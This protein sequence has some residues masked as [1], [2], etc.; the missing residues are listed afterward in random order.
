MLTFTD[1]LDQLEARLPAVPARLVHL[2]RTLAGATY[3][4]VTS[5]VATVAAAT[6]AFL[7]TTKT[8]GKTV[9][10][11]ATAQGR[12][13]ARSAEREATRTLDAAI[14]AVDDRP[15]SG[16][17]YEQWTRA[18]LLERAKETGVTGRTQMT[19][20]QLIAALRTS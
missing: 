19:K 2:Q 10:G 20:R 11:Q 1:Q 4:Q 16:T 3:D 15:G 6:R 9:A 14:D 17:P 8:A 12:Q 7:G 13:V 18:E 5:S